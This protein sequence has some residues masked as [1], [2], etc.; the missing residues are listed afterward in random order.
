VRFWS[1]TTNKKP[2]A[3]DKALK[4]LQD[5]D[6]TVKMA[7]LCKKP[8]AKYLFIENLDTFRAEITVEII[9]NV[10]D[11]PSPPAPPSPTSTT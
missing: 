5:G 3:S 10:L 2:V 7:S 6:T 4:L 11:P 8:N 9:G 1:D